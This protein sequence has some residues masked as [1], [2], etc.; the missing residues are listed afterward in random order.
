MLLLFSAYQRTRRTL[1][2]DQGR[3]LPCRLPMWRLLIGEISVLVR[4]VGR[5]R[6]GALII[7]GVL[8]ILLAQVTFT[9]ERLGPALTNPWRWLATA[10]IA[11]AGLGVWAIVH[12]FRRT[13]SG[14]ATV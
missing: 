10:L 12:A 1:A 11:T 2:K 8:A 6:V 7:G 14:R 13:G 9:P 3:P 4:R 5:L